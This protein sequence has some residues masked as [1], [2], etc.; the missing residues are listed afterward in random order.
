[1]R[2]KS[3]DSHYHIQTVI[4]SVQMCNKCEAL[5]L[6]FIQR[7]RSDHVYLQESG[8]KIS[9]PVAPVTQT[10]CKTVRLQRGTRIPEAT[11]QMFR[12]LVFISP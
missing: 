1:M 7:Q 8:R 4:R 3:L 10:L 2:F 6:S 9:S 12:T 11:P 5:T